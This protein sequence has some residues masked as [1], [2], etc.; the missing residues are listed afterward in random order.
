MTSTR[1]I[2][3]RRSAALAAALALLAACGGK[4]GG[5]GSGGGHIVVKGAFAPG[6]TLAAAAAPGALAAGGG[7]TIDNV[8]AADAS[9][10]FIFATR[11]GNGF[12]LS[13][14]SGRL[15]LIAFLSGTTTKA[16]YRADPSG[17]GWIAL[18]VTDASRDVDLGTLSFDA[19]GVGT[20]TTSPSTVAAD[21]GVDP[22]VREAL[23]L[24]DVAMQ[25][26]ANVDV[27]GDGTFDFQ[28]GRSYWFAIH[29]EFDPHRLF[30]E[31]Q[32]G[33]FSD[34]TVT[35]YLGYGYAFS[36]PAGSHDWNNATL[37]A[38]AT[39]TTWSGTQDPKACFASPFG[40]ATES[41]NFYCG[42]GAVPATI[43]VA[44]AQ[45]P[46]GDYT[47]TAPL[48][49]AGTDSYTFRDVGSQTIDTNLYNL[50]VPS[51]KLTMSGSKVASLDVKWWKNTPG[52]WVQP[53]ATELAAIMVH[54]GF[55][56]G[57]P[58]WAGSVSDRVGG[59][60]AIAPAASASVPAQS[61]TPG[62][63]RLEYRDAFGYSY[64]FEWR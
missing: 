61:F 45:P 46:T 6:I 15:Y 51:V 8:V 39:I 26:L 24:R 52:G 34:Q 28:Q 25:R 42:S 12:T 14:P 11:S 31:I 30:T 4:G 9:G 18:P 55:S 41:V 48:L 35:S 56:F 16:I 37:T 38:P 21:L 43:A 63:L 47:V 62:V 17:S 64:G 2:S 53:S 32:G 50:Y 27:D 3:G 20:G 1:P 29:H 7:A 57:Q 54:A 5:S 36:A 58:G 19:T 60:L 10:R 23:A 49:S 13:L 33:A 40:G 44:P 22:S 59:D